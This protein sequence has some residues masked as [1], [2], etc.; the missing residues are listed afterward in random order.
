MVLQRQQ[1]VQLSTCRARPQRVG[2]PAASVCVGG[3]LLTGCGLG[4]PSAEDVPV[5]VREAVVAL[6]RPP[7]DLTLAVDRVAGMCMRDLGYADFPLVSTLQEGAGPPNLAGAVGLLDASRART[8]GYGTRVGVAGD[9]AAGE[10]DGPIGAYLATLPPDQEATWEEAYDSQAPEDEVTVVQGEV[11]AGASGKGCLAEGRAKVYGSIENFLW[12]SYLPSEVVGIGSDVVNSRP[13]REAFGRYGDC[14]QDAGYDVNN[15]NDAQD[16][17]RERFGQRAQTAAPTPEEVAMAVTD[18][19]CQ[20]SSGLIDTLNEE[21][22]AN[23]ADYL[24]ENENE[25]LGLRAIQEDSLRRAAE[26]LRG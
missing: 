20:A 10:G 25:M 17:A 6:S 24:I 5:P 14:M 18:A 7:S 13:A 22:V 16:L 23:A 2:G 26:I 4:G 8:E 21:T 19:G 15:L 11:V 12:L 3:L 9:V 1:L